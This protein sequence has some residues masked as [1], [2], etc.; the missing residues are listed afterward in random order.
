LTPD[1]KQGPS[2]SG[3]SGAKR[4]VSL[5]M[6]KVNA[7]AIPV[8]FLPCLVVGGPFLLAWG[9]P[10]LLSGGRI[11]FH[12]QVI[13]PTLLGGIIAHELIHGLSWAVFGR[14]RLSTIRF[15]IHWKT[16]TP[17]AHC[18]QPMRASAYR[19]GA[20]MPAIV[21]GL[22]PSVYGLLVGDGSWT[23][24]GTIFLIAATGDFVVLWV[25][26]DVPG[27]A[28]VEDHPSRAGCFV[29]DAGSDSAQRPATPD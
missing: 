15:G 2:L 9:F 1:T 23:I 12:W 25:I 19:L 21:L 14:K 26:R 13:L 29:Y 5:S 11:L 27:T 22:L 24:Y 7:L 28:F 10:R 20:G 16:L 3:E 17:F 6:E 8:V 4:D 18:S